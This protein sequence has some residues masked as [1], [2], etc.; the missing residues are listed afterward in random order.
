M[1]GY[2]PTRL[3]FSING[4]DLGVCVVLQGMGNT[5]CKVCKSVRIFSFR[6]MC[7]CGQKAKDSE[8]LKM[9]REPGEMSTALMNCKLTSR[10]YTDSGWCGISHL[11]HRF[12]YITTTSKSIMGCRLVLYMLS[13][14][15]R[16]ILRN[17]SK[18]SS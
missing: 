1:S 18:S 5:V 8:S 17:V 13:L 7:R 15:Q 12:G 3:S 6:G 4:A 10:C 2:N 14:G 16:P 11:A 9:P